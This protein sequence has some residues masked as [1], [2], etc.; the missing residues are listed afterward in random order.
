[1]AELQPTLKF[2]GL[3][4]EESAIYLMLT[5]YGT[6]SVANIARV[7]K[8]GRVNCYHHLEK[9]SKKGL[10]SS[11]QK[12]KIKQFSA[13]NPRIFVNQEKERLNLAESI[14]PDLLNLAS[15]HPRKPKIQFFEGRQG[16]KNIFTAMLYQAEGEI[17]SFS[18]FEQLGGLFPEFLSQH[19]QRRLDQGIK[20]RFISARDQKA[21]EFKNN[22]FPA[23]FDHRLLE[24]F[25][26]SPREFSFDSEISIFKDSIAIMNLSHENP[27]GVLIENP[28]LYRT[29]KAI[30][31]LAWLG[32]TS[33]IT[34]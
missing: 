25:L 7:T 28:E 12:S 17:V 29:Q 5:E 23:E 32:A 24:I 14:V 21:E 15:Q 6:S 30:F 34:Q 16:I 4:D 26:I 20:T 11:S 31:D 2:L 13:E 22:F 10:V 19:F 33:F 18:N 1:M 3:T 27:I 8:L 9:L